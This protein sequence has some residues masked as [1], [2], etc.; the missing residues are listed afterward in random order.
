PRSRHK[1]CRPLLCRWQPGAARVLS[2]PNDPRHS[3]LSPTAKVPSKP[4]GVAQVEGAIWI[5]EEEERQRKRRTGR[6]LAV[7]AMVI[8]TVL[9]GTFCGTGAVVNMQRHKERALWLEFNMLRAEHDCC[10][11]PRLEGPCADAAARAEELH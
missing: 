8:A 10:M 5:V 3:A 11:G 1:V 2:G 7:I 4:V 6:A 9:F